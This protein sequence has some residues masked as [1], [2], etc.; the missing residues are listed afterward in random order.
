MFCICFTQEIVITMVIFG[1]REKTLISGSVK[2][3]RIKR[4][5]YLITSLLFITSSSFS[6]STVTSSI[7]ILKNS[8]DK[9]FFTLPD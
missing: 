3:I 1:L 9:R 4:T 7:P 2:I 6:I 5:T 8:S